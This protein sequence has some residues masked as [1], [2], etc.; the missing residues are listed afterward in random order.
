MVGSLCLFGYSKF[1]K[2]ALTLK[3]HSW[4]NQRPSEMTGAWHQECLFV[5]LSLRL[6]QHPWKA[7]WVLKPIYSN[8]SYGQA[9]QKEYIFWRS[10]D[11]GIR[12]SQEAPQKLS[13]RLPFLAIKSN[14]SCHHHQLTPDMSSTSSPLWTSVRLFLF[15]HSRMLCNLWIYAHMFHI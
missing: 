11:W 14:S 2:S 3:N 15:T 7:R 10:Y 4:R 1:K 12:W 9:W 13:S 8:D 5:W 6:A